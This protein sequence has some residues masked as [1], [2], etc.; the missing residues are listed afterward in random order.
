MLP[1]LVNAINNIVELVQPTEEEFLG[2]DRRRRR[3]GVFES[4]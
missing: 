4:L 2:L 3:E 1:T